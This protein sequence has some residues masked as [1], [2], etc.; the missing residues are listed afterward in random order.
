MLES[1]QVVEEI[2]KATRFVGDKTINLPLAF[3]E[4]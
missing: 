1:I 2:G 4:L 3:A